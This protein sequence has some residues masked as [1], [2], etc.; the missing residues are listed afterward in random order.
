MISLLSLLSVMVVTV[1]RRGVGNGARRGSRGGRDYRGEGGRDNRGEGGRGNINNEDADN[2]QMSTVFERADRSVST[3]HH[4]NVP[5]DGEPKKGIVS[6]T[7][8]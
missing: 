4:P 1:T 8:K 5:K 6:F 3:G 7:G 2:S